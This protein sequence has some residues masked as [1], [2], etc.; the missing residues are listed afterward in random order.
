MLF[1]LNGERDSWITNDYEHAV[2]GPE[3]Y[4]FVLVVKAPP[5]AAGFPS[6][7]RDISFVSTLA[8]FRDWLAHSIDCVLAWRS[9]LLECNYGFAFMSAWPPIQR[10]ELFRWASMVN[11]ELTLIYMFCPGNM[12]HREAATHLGLRLSGTNFRSTILNP[13]F[14]YRQSN[15]A[16]DRVYNAGIKELI[17]MV[18]DEVND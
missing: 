11:R 18:Y 10:D 1:F 7:C 6:A 17:E 5:A 16:I 15:S 3:V 14:W 12:S 4:S 8:A 13:H 9:S 2:L